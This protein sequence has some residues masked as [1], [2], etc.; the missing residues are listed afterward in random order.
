MSE[1]ATAEAGAS[2]DRNSRQHAVDYRVSVRLFGLPVYL[3]LL[4]GCD[5]RSTGRL[6]EDG[7]LRSLAV[8]LIKSGLLAL[9]GLSF[10]CMLLGLMVIVL[11]IVKSFIGIDIFDGPSSLHGLVY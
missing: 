2:P 6:Q 5:L 1:A 8:L 10:L 9:A 11:Y 4:A 3:V 7:Q